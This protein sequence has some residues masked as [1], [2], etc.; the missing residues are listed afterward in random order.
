MSAPA[1]D[2]KARPEGGGFFAIW[3]IRTFA[4]Y[5]GRGLTRPFLWPITAYFLAKRGPERRASMR[6]CAATGW[7]RARRLPAGGSMRRAGISGR[8]A[9]PCCASFTPRC[10]RTYGIRGQGLRPKVSRTRP[11]L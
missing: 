2:W 10:G 5:M 11:A 4:R 7:S 3:L 6:R 1:T 8:A 9:W